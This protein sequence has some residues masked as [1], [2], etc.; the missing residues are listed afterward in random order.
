MCCRTGRTN[1]FSDQRFFNAAAVKASF[2][3][4]SHCKRKCN[5]SFTSLERHLLDKA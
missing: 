4:K 1:I 5:D 3:G 2:V